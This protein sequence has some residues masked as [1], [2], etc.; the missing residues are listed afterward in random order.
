MTDRTLEHAMQ[1]ANLGDQAGT[2][3]AGLSPEERAH[4]WRLYLADALLDDEADTGPDAA[5][6]II[7]DPEG[8]PS[9]TVFRDAS[10]SYWVPRRP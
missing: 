1:F 8:G 3:W 10:W 4:A 6:L 7:P 2:S 9:T 5:Y